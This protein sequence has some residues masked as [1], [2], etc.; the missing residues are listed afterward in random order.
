MKQTDSTTENLLRTLPE[1]LLGWYRENARDLPWRH[2]EDPYRIWVSEIML[3]QTRVQAVLEYY[4]RFMAELPDVYALAAVGE[5]RLF[6]LWEG[7]GYYSR[8]RNLHRAAQVLVNDCGGEFPNTREELLRL[9][10][11]T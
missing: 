7:L 3:Q 2:T 8:A 6:K 9:P 4:A 11:A 1:P 5:E 10:G